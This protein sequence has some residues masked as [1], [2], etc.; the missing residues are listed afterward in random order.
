MLC[1]LTWSAINT[2]TKCKPESWRSFYHPTRVRLGWVDVAGNKKYPVCRFKNAHSTNSTFSLLLPIA[3]LAI[4]NFSLITSVTLSK[5]V[6][7]QQ[8]R[9]RS[10]TFLSQYIMCSYYKTPT[11]RYILLQLLQE[12]VTTLLNATEPSVVH[13]N[14]DG[15]VGIWTAGSRRHDLL[16]DTTLH[17]YSKNQAACKLHV[18]VLEFWWELSTNK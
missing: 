8:D 17:T 12:G 15:A 9:T 4:Y 14:T 6:V 3:M 10:L 5:D 7:K 13:R 18:C 16:L 1:F 11:A 2:C